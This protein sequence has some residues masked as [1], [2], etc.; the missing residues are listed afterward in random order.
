[1]KYEQGRDAGL[2]R[3]YKKCL[4]CEFSFLNK[5]EILKR[6]NPSPYHPTL[7]SFYKTFLLH[8]AVAKRRNKNNKYGKVLRHADITGQACRRPNNSV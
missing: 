8:V 6:Y 3:L 5:F 2:G 1:M 7:F 4:L